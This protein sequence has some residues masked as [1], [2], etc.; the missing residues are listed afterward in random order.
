[1]KIAILTHPLG[2]NYGGIL[3]AYALS[4]YLQTLGHQVSVLN[5][6]R[7]LPFLKRIIK[8]IFITLHF[9][10]KNNPR[11][12]HLVSFVKKNINYTKPLYTSG[13]I[14]RHITKNGI[15]TAIVGSDQVWRADFAMDYGYNYFLDFGPAGMRKLAYAAS[16]GLSE[17]KYTNNQTSNIKSLINDFF[18]ISVRED[19]GVIL[20]KKYLSVNAEQ[21]LD[22]TMLLI[23]EDYANITSDRLVAEDYIFV[24]WLGNDEVKNK[25]MSSVS[26]ENKKIVDISLRGNETLISVQDWLSYIKYADS[27]ITDSFHGCV[28]SILFKKQFNI[29]SNK[30]GGNGRLKSLFI[31][32]G[33]GSKIQ[34]NTQLIDY[35]KVSI[36]LDLQRKKSYEFLKSALQ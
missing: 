13:Q 32:L 23:I 3:Q 29:F 25:A 34:D 18:A 17:W 35:S 2:A 22:P 24:Y 6:Q 36:A 30:S 11:Y 20:C 31:A 7:N 10:R 5:R 1:M 21:V 9:S 8:V 33:I 19:E 26:L 4:K 15:K 16:L 12:K 27:V 28:F 14:T